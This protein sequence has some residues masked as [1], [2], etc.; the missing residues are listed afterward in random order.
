[1]KIAGSLFSKHARLLILYEFVYVANFITLS[2]ANNWFNLS[3]LLFEHNLCHNRCTKGKFLVVFTSQMYKT[4]SSCWSLN[5]EFS[6][7]KE[8]NMQ[9]TTAV[10][11]HIYLYWCE[12]CVLQALTEG[13]VKGCQP[14]YDLRSWINGV[15]NYK[16]SLLKINPWERRCWKVWRESII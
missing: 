1:M 16:S 3:A 13:E 8:V 11:F 12:R 15:N 7:K 2:E 5:C 14:F 9:S 6:V 4:I 10:D